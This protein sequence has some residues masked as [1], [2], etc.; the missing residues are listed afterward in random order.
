MSAILD[1]GVDRDYWE[2][3]NARGA[4]SWGEIWICLTF[5]QNKILQVS[6]SFARYKFCYHF[7]LIAY[8]ESA[9]L[10]KTEHMQT[11]FALLQKII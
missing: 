8:S 9:P 1:Y 3:A 4:L 5:L 7:K 11:N 2:F 6:L 10:Q